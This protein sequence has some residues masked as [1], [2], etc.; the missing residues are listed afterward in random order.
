MMLQAEKNHVIQ[1]NKG[2][3]VL[4]LLNF[5]EVV[6]LTSVGSVFHF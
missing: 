2:M 6:S 3:S 5:K 4:T 1:T